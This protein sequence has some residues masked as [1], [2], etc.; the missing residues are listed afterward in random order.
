MKVLVIN[1]P[2]LSRL[3][4]RDSSIYGD[5]TYPQLEALQLGTITFEAHRGHRG[6]HP[7]GFVGGRRQRLSGV[8]QAEATRPRASFTEHHER[9]RAVLPTL[10]EVRTAG[11]LA[12]RDEVE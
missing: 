3:D 5:M 9:R 8:D 11:F 4:I 7:I 2:N 10:G 12:H 6:G 1:G